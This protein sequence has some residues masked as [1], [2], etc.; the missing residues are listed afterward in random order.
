MLLLYF[1]KQNAVQAVTQQNQKG[2]NSTK[3][4]KYVIVHSL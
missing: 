4:Q 2:Q 1:T 3:K